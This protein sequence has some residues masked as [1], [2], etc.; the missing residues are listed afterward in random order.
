MSVIFKLSD[1]CFNS[2]IPFSLSDA[3][4]VHQQ[5]RKMVEPHLH[6]PTLQEAAGNKMLHPKRQGN[7]RGRILQE[8]LC[9]V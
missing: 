8:E 7:H 4:S 6:S 3:V 1:H 2:A 9:L 5:P